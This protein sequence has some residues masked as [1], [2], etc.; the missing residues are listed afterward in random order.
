LGAPPYFLYV[1][2]MPLHTEHITNT[3][4]KHHTLSGIWTCDPSC[5]AAADPCITLHG[6]QNRLMYK[7]QWQLDYMCTQYQYCNKQ[8]NINLWLLFWINFYCCV[9]IKDL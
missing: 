1:T 5:Q 8:Q 9:C 7:P 2:I 3:R 4:D 6:H